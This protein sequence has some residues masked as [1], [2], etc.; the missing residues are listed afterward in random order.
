MYPEGSGSIPEAP[1]TLPDQISDKFSAV[2]LARSFGIL[3][4]LLD[5]AGLLPG[6]TANLRNSLSGVLLGYGDLAKRFE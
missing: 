5:S 2:F 3:R 4:V 6:Y 1:G